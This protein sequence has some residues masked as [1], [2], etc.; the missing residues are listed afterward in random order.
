MTTKEA[1]QVLFENFAYDESGN[2][3]APTA[4]EALLWAIWALM[5]QARYDT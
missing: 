2:P 1:A 4:R 5:E 3:R